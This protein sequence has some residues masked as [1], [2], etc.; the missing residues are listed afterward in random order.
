MTRAMTAALQAMASPVDFGRKFI[1]EE[2]TPLYYTAVYGRL[3]PGHRLRYNQL[4]ALY[5][6]EQ[7]IFFETMIGRGVMQALQRHAWPDDFGDQVRRF[8]ADE[9]RHTRM[10]GQLNRR[11]APLY[12][13]AG[14]FHFIRAPRAWLAALRWATD[15]ARIFTLFLWLMLL[16]EERSLYYSREFIRHGGDLEPHFVACHRAHLADEVRH[17]RWDEELLERLWRPSGRLSRTMNARMF[18]WLTGEFFSTPKRGQL[19]VVDDLVREF[20]ELAGQ[21]QEL[22][23]QLARLPD[24]EDYQRSLYSRD[25][26]P[27]CFAR[28]DQW[29]ELRVMERAI[30]GYRF[31]AE[32]AR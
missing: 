6:N 21:A 27:E 18:A 20:P 28:F 4:Q 23:R 32:T 3:A 22:R 16:Q 24:D 13:A 25:I 1:P 15:H 8:A 10:F 19:G 12:Y 17:V 11:C 30:S 29:P 7:I 9:V 14:D 26:V 5:F 2:L 31:G